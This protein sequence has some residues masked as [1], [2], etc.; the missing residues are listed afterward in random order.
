V[1]RLLVTAKAVPSSPILIIFM[2]EVIE[3]PHVVTSQKIE[4]FMLLNTSELSQM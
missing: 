2:M 3:E 1:L 4:F